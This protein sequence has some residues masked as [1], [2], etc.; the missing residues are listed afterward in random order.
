M[1]ASEAWLFYSCVK[2]AELDTFTDGMAV[3]DHLQCNGVVSGAF[4]V[5]GVV[6]SFD[7]RKKGVFL[8]NPRLMPPLTQDQS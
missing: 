7:K 2:K 1:K 3:D 8:V 4:G 5:D 6:V